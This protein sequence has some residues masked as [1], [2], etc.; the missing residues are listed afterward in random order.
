MPLGTD[1]QDYLIEQLK[2]PDTA[3][4]YIMAAIEE[5]DPDY[6]NQALGNVVKAYGIAKISRDCGLSR[7]ALY[8]MFSPRGNPTLTNIHAILGA[9]GLKLVIAPQKKKKS[10]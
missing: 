7:Q 2:N 6:L 9:V 1:F 8:K 5:N 10:A 4:E 3:A